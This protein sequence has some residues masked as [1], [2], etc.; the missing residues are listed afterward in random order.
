MNSQK[1]SNPHLSALGVE[2]YFTPQPYHNL[3]AAELSTVRLGSTLDMSG[4]AQLNEKS[5]KIWVSSIINA[6]R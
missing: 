5:P 2:R 3:I 4:V 6:N 1:R